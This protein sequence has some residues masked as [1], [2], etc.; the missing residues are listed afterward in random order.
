MIYGTSSDVTHNTEGKPK[1]TEVIAKRG[2]KV[3]LQ[4]RTALKDLRW[5]ED[6]K[7]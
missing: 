5:K 4:D 6:F 3:S 2:F 7:S 1:M